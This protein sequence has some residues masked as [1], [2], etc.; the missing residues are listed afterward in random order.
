[1]TAERPSVTLP[2][3][4]TLLVTGAALIASGGLLAAAG[5][6]CATYVGVTAARAWSRQLPTPPNELARRK[7][8]QARAA[9]EAAAQAWRDTS[10][11]G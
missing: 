7:L 5:V 11:V 1:M 10:T 9:S 2:F 8:T 3:N 4:R 6:V